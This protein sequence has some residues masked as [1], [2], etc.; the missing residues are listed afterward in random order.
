MSD[1]FPLLLKEGWPDHSLIMIQ[2]LIPAGVVDCCLL[3]FRALSFFDFKMDHNSASAEVDL[4]LGDDLKNL[5]LFL[6]KRFGFF[7]SIKE[8]RNQRINHPGRERKYC[9]YKIINPPDHPSF[10]RRGNFFLQFLFHPQSLGRR[11]YP[12][13]R[14]VRT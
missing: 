13:R 12:R 11:L 2:M 7:I 9:I 3:N 6:L 5:R 8:R 14:V 1:T 10:K 4:F